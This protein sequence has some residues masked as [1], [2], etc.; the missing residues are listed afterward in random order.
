MDTSKV[1]Y[2]P[3]AIGTVQPAATDAGEQVAKAKRAKHGAKS[4]DAKDA[5]L[6]PGGVDVNLSPRARQMAEAHRKAMEIARATPDVRADKVADLKRRV[7][8]GSYKVEPEKVA[9]GIMREA[10]IEHLA[11]LPQQSEE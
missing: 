5:A 9:D 4:E 6:T 10:M 2:S 7:Q 1:A 3:S 11:Q 8:D